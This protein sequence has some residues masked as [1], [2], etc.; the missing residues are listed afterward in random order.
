MKL[1]T[2]TSR[3][4]H[5]IFEKFGR[6][7]NAILN[8]GMLGTLCPLSQCDPSEWQR[9]FAVN[10]TANVHLVRTLHPLL[11]HAPQANIVFVTSSVAQN[12]HAYWGAYAASKAALENMAG[13]YEQEV[14]NANITVSVFDP[15]GTATKMRAAA[16]PG[17]NPDALPSAGETAERLVKSLD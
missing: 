17:E 11:N 16:F 15:G 8:A 9:V 10:V 5:R 3:L 1:A 14:A 6:L 13:V 2:T 7:D 4:F 12:P